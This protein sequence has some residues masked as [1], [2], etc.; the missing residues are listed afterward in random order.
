MLDEIAQWLKNMGF[1][2]ANRLVTAAL[3][4]A[5]GVCLI[6]ILLALVRRGLEASKLEK[7]AHTLVLSL[8]RVALYLM[9]G[10]S[11]A[12]SLGIDVTGVVALASVLT[13][14]VSLALQNML[15]NVLGGF[16]LLTT[17]PFHSGDFVDIGDQSGTVTAIDMTYTRLMT[18]DNK[19]VCIPN[20]T[21]MSATVVNYSAGGIRRAELKI[22]AGYDAPTQKVI[23]ALVLAATVDNALLEPA[24]FAAVESYGDNAIQ[25]IL[26]FWVKTSEYWDVYFQV[27]QRVKTVFDQQGIQ[28][29]YPHLN[30][31]LDPPE[32]SSGDEE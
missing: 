5:V 22:S 19:V 20:S 1:G 25:Y 3:V 18:L 13:L 32:E 9:L 15:T 16:A 11:V 8:A 29:T 27:N 28:M 2:A 17:H 26:R 23:D 6:K 7:A 21:V 24:P 14:A 30:V 4:L 12:S 10:L 31:H